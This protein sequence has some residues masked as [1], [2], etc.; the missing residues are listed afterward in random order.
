MKK[1]LYILMCSLLVL[2]SCEKDNEPLVYPPT[3]A[4]I[5]VEETTRFEATLKGTAIPHP[6]SII[7]CEIGFML[8]TSQSMN[9]AMSYAAKKEANNQYVAQIIGLTPGKQYYTCIYAKSGNTMTKGE[10]TRFNT[11]ESVA[12]VL[13]EPMEQAKSEESIE[14]SSSIVDDGGYAPS[15]RG[16][17]YK[18]YV[19]GDSEPSTDD[20]TVLL[21]MTAE[22]FSAIITGLDPVTTYV[23]RAYAI[24]ETGTGYS[25][26]IQVTTN[27]LQIPSVSISGTGDVSAYTIAIKAQVNSDEG[28]AV[29]EQGVCWSAESN[30]PTLSGKHI[31]AATTNANYE[32]VAGI[33]EGDKLTPNTKYYLRAYAV[34]EKGV[35]Y[36]QAI[37]VSTKELEM[38]SLTKVVIDNITIASATITAQVEYNENTEIKEVGVCYSESNAS[39]TVDDVVVKGELSNKVL[40]A[41]LNELKE[42]VT[43][44]AVTY[45]LTRDGYF[46]SEPIEFATERTGTAAITTPSISD[47]LETQATM[48]STIS[49]NGG[50]EITQKG[51]CW[52]STNRIPALDDATE[53]QSLTVES[54]DASIVATINKLTKGTKYFV[55]S[56][57]INRNGTAYSTTAEF[58][59]AETFTPTVGNPS[60]SNI[61]ETGG[62]VSAQVTSDGGAEITETGICYS[63]T[64]TEPTTANTKIATTEATENIRITLDGLSKGNTYFVRAYAINRNGTAYSVTGELRTMQNVEPTVTGITV[65]NIN[66]DNAIGKAFMA[67]AGGKGL[68]IPEK[69]FVWGGSTAT[70][71]PPTI[72]NCAG[73]VISTSTSDNFE[74]KL[75]GLEYSREYIVRAYATNS[76]GLTGYSTPIGFFTGSSSMVEF[77]NSVEQ[78]YISHVTSSGAK[79]RAL[80]HSDGGAPISKV[81]ICWAIGNTPSKDDT[82]Y[83]MDYSDNVIELPISNLKPETS[84]YARAYAINKNGV[85]YSYTMY[86]TT[87]KTPPQEGDNELPGTTEGKRPEV[88]NLRS[89][90]TF[91]DRLELTAEIYNDGGLPITA[92]GF[93]W[94]QTQYSPE[95]GQEGTTHIPVTTDGNDMAT[96]LRGLT[97]GTY[98]YVSVYAT[99]E[100]GTTYYSTSFR[101]E[102]DK[103]EPG[104]GD[105]PT[106]EI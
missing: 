98:Y 38:A 3:L 92:K 86:F 95:I 71:P 11:V 1:L 39:P 52:S 42:G 79:L 85:S 61:T 73:K 60:F 105:N 54:T 81:G 46:Y 47:I 63:T 75:T 8:S 29:S 6:L 28:Y 68:T 66:D 104:E 41:Q 19:V 90:G 89:T 2:S 88:G 14:L 16:F 69:G 49:S 77:N 55:R 45:A 70:G 5:Q 84:Y 20:T 17:A 44:H 102:E 56:Y 18:K 40:T 72:T 31:S 78:T 97:P 32:V 23:I 21:P 94:S 76:E 4:N 80:I 59:T 13:E 15:V 50:A 57:A 101:T 53:S 83:E 82:A 65:M 10:V 64:S 74:A 9:N 62:Q 87:D 103:P 27:K 34:N 35:G 43:Y 26:S 58:T 7:D 33:T 100:K 30:Q 96:V 48:S 99:N 22:D 51:V 25:Q 91:K 12:P 24:N 106:P 37:E 93:V 67:D 36:S